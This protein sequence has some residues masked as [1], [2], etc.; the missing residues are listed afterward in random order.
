MSLFRVAMILSILMLNLWVF[1][2]G[3]NPFRH[4]TV[5]TLPNGHFLTQFSGIKYFLLD[6]VLFIQINNKTK[7][8]DPRF[9]I[10]GRDLRA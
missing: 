4:L 3:S 1:D 8:M 10:R 7:C 5:I 2:G 9:E 6:L